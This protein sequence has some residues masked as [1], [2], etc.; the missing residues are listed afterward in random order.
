MIRYYICPVIGTGQS[1]N[2]S[3]RAKVADYGVI[4]SA[5]IPLKADGTP[6][7]NKTLVLVNATDFNAIDAD[8]EIKDI[9]ERFS[10]GLSRV[11][12]RNF[13]QNKTVGDIPAAKRGRIQTYLVSVG[14]DLTGITLSSTLWSV[15]Q[16]VYD[17]FEPSGDL[18]TLRAE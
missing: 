12:L 6:R 8:P 15:A 17:L 14:V 13:L 7:F 9:F 1:V 10:D 11:Q 2:D 3:W 4:H 5:L 18:D 16:R